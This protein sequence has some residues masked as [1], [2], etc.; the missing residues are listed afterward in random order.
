M[1][2]HAVMLHFSGFLTSYVLRKIFALTLV[3]MEFRISQE[4]FLKE[5]PMDTIH[6]IRSTVRTFDI[7]RAIHRE[8]SIPHYL[9]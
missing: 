9:A 1:A 4:H 2:T 5:L 3:A 6:Y 7:V 8:D